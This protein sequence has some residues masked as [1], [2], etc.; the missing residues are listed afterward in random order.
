MLP[1]HGAPRSNDLQRG[2]EETRPTLPAS[3]RCHRAPP[4]QSSPGRGVG[5][6]DRRSAAPLLARSRDRGRSLGRVRFNRFPAQA[7]SG[8]TF[9]QSVAPRMVVR[10]GPGQQ[11]QH[12]PGGFDEIDRK[13]GPACREVVPGRVGPVPEGEADHNQDNARHEK[14][15]AEAVVAPPVGEYGL[16]SR[17]S[18]LSGHGLIRSSD[19]ATE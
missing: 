18:V 12:A 9:D 2:R 14:R 6:R 5:R 19:P 3:E 15:E 4:S 17:G 8:V 11:D 7:R 16:I 1:E 13:T 10:D